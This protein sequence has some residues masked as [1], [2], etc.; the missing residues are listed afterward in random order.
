MQGARKLRSEAHILG[1]PQ[2]F[3]LLDIFPA[4]FP[5]KFRVLII[6]S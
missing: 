2:R 4:D 5:K 6:L 1:A 3:T